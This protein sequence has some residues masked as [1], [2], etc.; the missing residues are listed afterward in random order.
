MLSLG[1]YYKS[2]LY[3]PIIGKYESQGYNFFNTLYEFPILNLALPETMQA[4]YN[5]QHSVV[6]ELTIEASIFL[7]GSLK[8]PS[9]KAADGVYNVAFHPDVQRWTGQDNFNIPIL[10]GIFDPNG[11]EPGSPHSI[12]FNT[13]APVAVNKHDNVYYSPNNAQFKLVP[14][15]KVVTFWTAALSPDK[16][17][18]AINFNIIITDEA[19]QQSLHQTIT[20]FQ[21]TP[22]AQRNERLIEALS[23]AAVP[24]P[25]ADHNA[26]GAAAIIL[27]AAAR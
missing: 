6:H 15:R 26:L 25:E 9:N 27:A 16:R 8:D 2:T 4:A 1:L 3:A 5:A 20:E 10:M 19:L 18:S 24:L 12:P 14:G 7:W 17:S 11:V 13:F 21:Y 23:E 22:P